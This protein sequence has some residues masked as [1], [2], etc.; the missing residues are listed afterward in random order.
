MK[1]ATLLK[2]GSVILLLS[3]A[4][5]VGFAAGTPAGTAISNQASVT[6]LA[7]TNPRSATSNTVTLYV[8]HHV[9]GSFT[10]TSRSDGGVDNRTVYYAVRFT[11]QGNR[12]D[13]FN[14]SFNS[15]AGYT[16]A[17]INDLNGN[18][19]FDAG[20]PVITSTG[21]LAAD[22]VI[23]MLVRVQ[24]AAG[25]SD[26]ENV[27]ITATLTSTA[28]DDAPNHIVVANPGAAF[29]FSV[30]YTVQKPVIVFTASQQAVFRAPMSRTP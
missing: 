5:N 9:V 17:M 16:V 12:T 2:S 23:N 8:A 7:G 19:T 24:I 6:Y 29:T 1:A 21:S 10:P 14:I 26:N 11:N 4:A 22:A 25:R 27:T 13:A 15:N 3:F 28:T 18:G 30:A 20:E